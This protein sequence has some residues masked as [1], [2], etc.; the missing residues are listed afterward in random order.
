MV[1]KMKLQRIQICTRSYFFISDTM[2]LRTST[3]QGVPCITK[4]NQSMGLTSWPFISIWSFSQ[5]WG[6]EKGASPRVRQASMT[7][8]HGNFEIY[9]I[10]LTGVK[11]WEPRRRNLLLRKRG[12]KRRAPRKLFVVSIEKKICCFPSRPLRLSGENFLPC[13]AFGSLSC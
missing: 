13:E 11:F 8:P 3:T 5:T 9:S 10:V 2:H 12:H 7:S 1:Q 6:G 4:S